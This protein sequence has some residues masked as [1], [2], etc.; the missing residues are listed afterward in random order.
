MGKATWLTLA[1]SLA[2]MAM[3]LSY[4]VSMPGRS[5]S[6][7]LPPLSDAERALRERLEGHVR[8]V[9]SHE[10]NLWTIDAL[11]AAAQYIEA[12]LSRAGYAVQ[13]EEYRSQGKAVRNLF[14]E[15]KGAARAEEI[16][17]VG[18][19]YDSV[20][21]A[22]GANDNGSGVA[23]VLELARAWRDWRPARTW[24]LVLF[25]NEEPPFFQSGEMGSQ[26]HAAG[27][28]ARKEEIVAMYSLETIGWYSDEPG[29]QRYPFPLNFF[30]PERGNFLAFVSN[31][32]SRALLHKTI[33]AF[34][35][36]AK[37]PSEGVA[38][39][40]W[41]PGVDWSDHASFWEAGFD[42]L[43]VT[44]TAPYRYPHYHLAS[45]T[46]DKVHYEKLARV[47]AGLEKAFRVVDESR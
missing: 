34:R 37:F 47:V 29:S 13:R 15:I 12:Q 7:P 10:H 4:M 9:A 28:R 20:L 3:F 45:D 2:A 6:G 26:R 22:P 31:L 44:D 14:V 33:V 1:I 35:S 39:P 32:S 16:V 38:A 8:A 23:A 11:E 46:P 5:W 36:E 40:A 18:A 25:V 43:M 30:Y 41:I 42:A 17:V 19:H 27:A 24:R 21:G